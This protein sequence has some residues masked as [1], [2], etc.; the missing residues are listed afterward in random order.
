MLPHVFTAPLHQLL[1]WSNRRTWCRFGRMKILAL[2]TVG[3]ISSHSSEFSQ[4]LQFEV[5]NSVVYRQTAMPFWQMHIVRHQSEQLC[6]FLG[7]TLEDSVRLQEITFQRFACCYQRDQFLSCCR[8][9][10]NRLLP[11]KS[12]MRRL[13]SI[14]RLLSYQFAAIGSGNLLERRQSAGRQILARLEA[15]LLWKFSRRRPNP[16]FSAFRSI[17]SYFRH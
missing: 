5:R 1:F 9:W 11:V 16:D 2:K 12:V 13:F 8:V 14:N 3:H 6:F 7:R 10:A 15:V 4:A 17:P